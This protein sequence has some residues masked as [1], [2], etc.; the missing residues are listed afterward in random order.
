[1][2]D[3]QYLE[4]KD[5]FGKQGKWKVDYSGAVLLGYFLAL[6]DFDSE[7]IVDCGDVAC[8]WSMMCTYV[9]QQSTLVCVV[10][11]CWIFSRTV[12]S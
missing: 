2:K 10:G 6:G 12:A 8:M 9:C 11:S 1:V 4:W 7:R 3:P 5:E